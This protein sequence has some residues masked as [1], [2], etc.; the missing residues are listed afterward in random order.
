MAATMPHATGPSLYRLYSQDGTLLYV[1]VS[2]QPSQRL[3]THQSRTWWPSVARVDVEQYPT[4]AAAMAAERAAIINEAPTYNIIGND[5]A[6]KATGEMQLIDDS[7]AGQL[8]LAASQAARWTERRND[9]VV[10]M[11]NSGATL[12]GIA[13]VVG[14]SHVAVVGIL[15]TR[16]DT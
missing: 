3:T 8:R 2:L 9:L 15:K 12:R 13:E 11:R 10:E 16:G 14:L 4:K 6:P 7:T 5:H 1:G